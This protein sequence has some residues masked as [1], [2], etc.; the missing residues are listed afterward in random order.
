MIVSVLDLHVRI[1]A[2]WRLAF[3]RRI[4]KFLILAKR[5]FEKGPDAVQSWTNAHQ[6]C[7]C[8]SRFNSV[9]N[10]ETA[11]EKGEWK[12]VKRNNSVDRK[13]SEGGGTDASS[14]EK[15]PS[16]QGEAHG[17]IDCAPAAQGYHLEQISSCNHGG[18]HSAML[19]KAWRRQSPWIL[20]KEQPQAGAV[21]CGDLC[22]AAPKGWAT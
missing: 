20:L 14:E 21:A 17:G 19:D 6:L 11:N 8:D 2:V 15:F 4:Q 3:V 16:S 22:G 9:K 10:C 7:F 5:H 1:L 12:K 18:A 13:V